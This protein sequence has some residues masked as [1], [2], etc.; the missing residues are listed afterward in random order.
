MN[1]ERAS[2][3]GYFQ[4]AWRGLL[5]ALATLVVVLG[6][7]QLNYFVQTR[8][9][10]T[11]QYFVSRPTSDKVVIVAIDEKTIAELGLQTTWS[12]AIYGD[13]V[14]RLLGAG[15]RVVGFDILFDQQREGDGQQ[16]CGQLHAA[17]GRRARGADCFGHA[18]RRGANA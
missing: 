14:E 13:L 9:A 6:L 4:P 10:L 17:R 3:W 15:V 1:D 12:R 11:N 18:L 8:L 2:F 16:G 5:S 7:W